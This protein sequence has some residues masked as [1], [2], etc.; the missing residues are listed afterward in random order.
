MIVYVTGITG[1][2]GTALARAHRDRG[3]RVIGCARSESRIVEWV[4]ENS[5]EDVVNC[6]DAANIPF[7]GVVTPDVLYHCAALKHVERCEESPGEA[8]RNNVT[9][10]KTVAEACEGRVHGIFLSSDKAVSPGSGVYG[11]TKLLSERIALEHQQTVVRLGNLIGS[12]GSVFQKWARDVREGRPIRVTDRRCTRF[13]YPVDRAVKLLMRVADTTAFKGRVNLP[14]DMQSQSMGVVAD[15]VSKNVEE[16][17]L[18]PGETLHQWIESPEYWTS[19]N[20]P[21]WACS[22]SADRWDV[23]KLLQAARTAI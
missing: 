3:D 5:W 16:T 11:V 14:D 20:K 2:L 6:G 4:R 23:D 15:H 9:L 21:A 17:G 13:F 10:T 8:V 1:T 12:S 22:S 18:R 19:E 7:P